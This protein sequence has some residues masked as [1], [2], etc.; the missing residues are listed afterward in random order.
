MLAHS[1]SLWSSR[2]Q[3]SAAI[4]WDVYGVLLVFYGQIA[5]GEYA[6][7]THSDLNGK[8]R[9]LA[10]GTSSEGSWPRI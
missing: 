8:K 4:I 1:S 9:P 2:T 5:N 10:E 3:E 7:G 6:H